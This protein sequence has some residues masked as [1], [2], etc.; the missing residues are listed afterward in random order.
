MPNS[1]RIATWLYILS[2]LWPLVTAGI[3]VMQSPSDS[4]HTKLSNLTLLLAIDIPF[5]GLLTFFIYQLWRRRNWARI[6]LLT[7]SI[8]LV[9]L[10]SKLAQA[11]VVSSGKL[12]ARTG[13]IEALAQYGSR[14]LLVAAACCL[15]STSA[16]QCLTTMQADEAISDLAAESEPMNMPKSTR[17]AIWLGLIAL[18][19]PIAINLASLIVLFFVSPENSEATKPWFILWEMFTFF[20][21]PILWIEGFLLYNAHKRKNWAR[22]G[23]GALALILLGSHIYGYISV[24]NLFPGMN[25]LTGGWVEQLAEWLPAWVL[26][27]AVGILF[28]NDSREWFR[29]T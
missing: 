9:A 15:F 24:R 17:T 13:F 22:Y 6:G 21:S 8:F 3:E 4:L 2:A 29:N 19:L 28:T 20:L 18:L 16:K 11:P 5:L 23:L 1:I 14:G 26:L 27:G 7:L 10:A 25:P 12:V